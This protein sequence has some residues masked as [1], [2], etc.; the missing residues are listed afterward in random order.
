MSVAQKKPRLRDYVKTWQSGRR[1]RKYPYREMRVFLFMNYIQGQ[2]L[3]KAA[4]FRW[5]WM[6]G[7][8]RIIQC[9]QSGPMWHAWICLR[10]VLPKHSRVQ[11]GALLKSG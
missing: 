10:W 8:P 9:R 2:A 3:V 7:F 1:H 6:N 4:C 5:R 11:S